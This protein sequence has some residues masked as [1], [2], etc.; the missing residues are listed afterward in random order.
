[1]ISYRLLPIGNLICVGLFV[2]SEAFGQGIHNPN[3][4][5]FCIEDSP[6]FND[7]EITL[8]NFED[9]KLNLPGV[10]N[11]GGIVLLRNDIFG[12]SVDCDDGFIDNSGNSGGATTGA[13]YSNGL[14]SVEFLFSEMPLNRLPSRIGLVV[15]DCFSN[16]EFELRAYRN[17]V[18]LGSVTGFHI[19]EG[20]NFTQQDRFY[21]FADPLGIDRVVLHAATDDDWAID[22][23]QYVIF[24]TGDVNCDGTVDLLDVGPFVD[25]LTSSE[26][27][28]KADINHDGVV[29]LLDIEPF[30]ELLTGG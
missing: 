24:S 20:Q 17:G 1:M 12:D 16:T 19:A 22:H 21:G 9:G 29:N 10:T 4:N 15:T 8:E 5:Y 11:L 6:L 30:V 13:F 7:G 18:E 26:F 27:F 3:E 2:C 25:A 23:I 14:Q 28:P